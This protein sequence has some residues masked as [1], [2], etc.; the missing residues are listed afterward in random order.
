MPGDCINWVG[1]PLELQAILMKLFSSQYVFIWLSFHLCRQ[2]SVC[3]SSSSL[4]HTD[5]PRHLLIISQKRGTNTTPSLERPNFV[6]LFS[7]FSY[8]LAH[9]EKKKKKKYARG[10]HSIIG[11]TKV[12]HPL[13]F[14][15]SIYGVFGATRRSVSSTLTFSMLSRSLFGFD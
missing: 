1:I 14:E 15:E 5:N 6:H 9:F 11:S 3:L 2:L 13:S 12:G 7:D 4:I 10:R 8:F